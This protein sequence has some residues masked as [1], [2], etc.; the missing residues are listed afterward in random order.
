MRHTSIILFICLVTPIFTGLV[1]KETTETEQIDCKTIASA[2]KL[3]NCVL[4]ENPA[5]KSAPLELKA[6]RAA[7]KQAT[8]IPNPE[9][10]GR[11]LRGRDS[12]SAEFTL[13]HT[14]VGGDKRAARGEISDGRLNI[15]Q[16]QRR[17]VYLKI[18]GETV[19]GLR[20]LRHLIRE[21]HI[22][23]ETRGVLRRLIGKMN[24]TSFLSPGASAGREVFRIALERIRYEEDEIQARKA[25][26]LGRLAYNAGQ[27]RLPEKKILPRPDIIWPGTPRATSEESPVVALA[28]ARTDLARARLK[29]AEEEFWPDIKI[30]PTFE[31]S[32]RQNSA[33]N[34]LTYNPGAGSFGYGQTFS[35]SSRGGEVGVSFSLTLPLYN[36]NQNAEASAR[37]SLEKEKELLKAA[38]HKNEILRAT[39]VQNYEK[40][41][42]RFQATGASLKRLEARHRSTRGKILRGL[43][44]PEMVVEFHREM[45]ELLRA[46]NRMEINALTYLW[47]VYSLSGQSPTREELHG[48]L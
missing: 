20:L 33:R 14:L 9:L 2:R 15:V 27:T 4:R 7:R 32:S 46:R 44:R 22:L 43:I 18:A 42:S 8:Q 30:G 38:L 47:G 35:E 19:M 23:G 13:R 39:L 5:L 37:A 34:L 31:Y 17:L 40:A 1:G 45:L 41:M 11:V 21:E 28:R 24:R 48:L 26:L 36:Q 6:L 29:L 3:Y 10:E 16:A 25:T 12:T